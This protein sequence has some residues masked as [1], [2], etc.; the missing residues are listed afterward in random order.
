MQVDRA[1]LS[2][3]AGPLQ[4]DDLV[5]DVGCGAG[6]TIRILAD[7]GIRDVG[8][9]LSLNMIDEAQRSNTDL[10]YEIGS[11]RNSAVRPAGPPTG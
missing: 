1:M 6:A 5:A 11:I 4:P 7:T 2:A 3:F 10:R 9:G 8:I